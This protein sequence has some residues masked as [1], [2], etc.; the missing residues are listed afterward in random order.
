MWAEPNENGISL[1]DIVL[2][3]LVEMEREND[4]RAEQTTMIIV[5]SKSV[6][7]ADTGGVKGYD[8]GKKIR[9]KMAYCRGYPGFA[10]RTH[11]HTS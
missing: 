2:R 10:S 4:D 7:N 9:H 8:A 11:A 6:Q 3:K 5:D 1:L